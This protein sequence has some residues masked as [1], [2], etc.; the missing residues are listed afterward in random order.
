MSELSRS[1]CLTS[2]TWVEVKDHLTHDRRLLVPVGTCDQHGPHLPIGTSTLIAEAFC[3][4][5][6]RDFGVLRAPA[7]EYGVNLPSERSYAG[8]ATL[9][10]K[11]LHRM[12]ND[13]L[14]SWEDHGFEEFILITA[15]NY[16]PHVEALATI[17][18]TQARVRV[19]EV[20]SI[21]LTTFL[22]GPNDAAH[23]GEVETSLM[24]HLHPDRVQMDKAR[25]FHPAPAADVTSH[26]GGLLRVPAAS[27]GSVG[28]ST[29]ASAEKGRRIYEYIVEKIR[30]K[31]FLVA[32]ASDE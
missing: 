10:E 6:S 18:G 21:D 32:S 22:D 11:T 19:I 27:P 31:V 2:L 26:T 25:D 28:S 20:L 16:D 3:D 23:G 15:Y 8:A 4:E 5:L 30:A 17:I 13:L 14:A 7:L 9:R 1:L 12:L 24:L 29:L